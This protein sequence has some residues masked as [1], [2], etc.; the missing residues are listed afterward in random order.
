MVSRPETRTDLIRLAWP[1]VGEDELAE[2]REVLES[3]QLTMG[4]KVGELEALLAAAAGT[5]HAVAVSSGRCTSP[6]SR[7][8]SGPATRC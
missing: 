8:G 5:A 1:D 2:I 3:G 6:C 4:E 7:S